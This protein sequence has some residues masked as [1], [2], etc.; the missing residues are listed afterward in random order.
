MPRLDPGAQAPAFALS[1]Q[2]G[3]TVR[4]GQFKGQRVLLYFYPR[5]D[6]PGCTAQSCAV[7]DARPELS[8]H[9]V[10]VL[11]VSPD[12]PAAQQRFA[13]K[14]GLGFPLLSDANHDVAADYGVWAE[15]SMY[16]KKY[17]GIV[18]SAF[19]I[20]ERG[21]IAHAWYKIS[22]ADTVPRALAALTSRT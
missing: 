22:P 16:G 2:D 1:D 19:L 11:G 15:K 4:L 3:K 18:R 21:R 10:V 5:A 12:A 13:A 8:R 14:Y 7:R 20:E 9:G 17:W 6:T